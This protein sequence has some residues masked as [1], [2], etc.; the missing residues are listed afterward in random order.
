[1]NAARAML[2]DVVRFAKRASRVARALTLS[3]AIPRW[4]KVLLLV[5]LLPVPGPFDEIM[6][7]VVV[8]V[9]LRGVHRATVLNVWATS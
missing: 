4:A 8:W 6:G 1:M 3:P 5:A 2:A 7:A 9:L